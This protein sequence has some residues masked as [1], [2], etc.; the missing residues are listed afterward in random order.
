M[1]YGKK[2]TYEFVR[3]YF[4]EQGC[5]MLEKEYKNNRTKMKFK[6][7]RGNASK[8]TFSRFQQGCRCMKCGNKIKSEKQKLTY[9]YVKQY[10]K[11]RGCELLEKEYINRYISMEYRC[12]CGNILKIFFDS[13]QQKKQGEG[14][15]KCKGK[16]YSG[17]KNYR[18]IKDRKIVKENEKFRHKCYQI[19][20]KALKRIGQKKNSRTKDLL[21]YT[22]KE[23][24]NYIYNHSNWENVKDKEW[25]LDHV[26][27][28]KAFTDYNIKDVKLINS[29]DN[30][31][32][33]L[34]KENLI[35]S[36]KYDKDEFE[37]WLKEKKYEF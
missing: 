7:F 22:A 25:H 15:S 11:D 9:E 4:E 19:L 2:F 5:E 10:F 31:Q 26:F 21:G 16:K 18:W 27:P 35:K 6:C 29:L 13:F 34:K 28:I 14:C 20:K 23:M 17:E 3:N 1:A 8:I 33:L 24:Q 30:L 12:T 36:Y 37:S 32:P